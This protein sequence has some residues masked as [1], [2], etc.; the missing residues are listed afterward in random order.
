MSKTSGYQVGGTFLEVLRLSL[1]SRIARNRWCRFS[2]RIGRPETFRMSAN[3]RKK[4]A[5][6]S[7]IVFLLQPDG[8]GHA[9]FQR[10]PRPSD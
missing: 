2:R 4:G 9:A 5:G 7:T 1:V 10:D 6:I 3:A 8:R